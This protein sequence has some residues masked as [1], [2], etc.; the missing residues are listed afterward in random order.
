M[1]SNRVT[2]RLSEWIG[3][4]ASLAVAMLLLTGCAGEE[5]IRTYRVAK[6]E[7]QPA[8]TPP[9]A[10][11]ASPSEDARE[12][13]MLGAIIPKGRSYWVFK[14]ADSPDVVSAHRDEFRE[15]I[16]SLTF[17]KADPQ[18]DLAE[19]WKEN[20]AL[21]GM[22]Y[23]ELLKESEGLRATVTQLPLLSD[24]Q[25]TVKDNINRW[26]GQ[27]A[28]EPSRDWDSL[29]Q[30]LE[31]VEGLNEGDSKAYFVSLVGKGTG[32]MGGGPFQGSSPPSVPRS[33]PTLE[34]TVNPSASRF[35]YKLPDGWVAKEVPPGGMRKA[36]F[37]V[38]GD[39]GSAEVTIVSAG[40]EIRGNVGMWFGQ[41]K[42]EST[43]EAF[44]K[45][46]DSAEPRKINELEAKLYTVEGT[47]D[48]AQAILVAEVPWSERE[49]LFIKM[50]GDAVIVQQS[51]SAF[52]AFLKSLRW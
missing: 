40:G 14:L 42:V 47:G 45:V 21:G 33:E 19:G 27:L 34:Q 7:N 10:G 29:E 51:R 8:F 25:K 11:A 3:G 13:Q 18:W 20:K 2:N 26:R 15:M 30:D 43:D 36:A 50:K 5:G 41:V 38:P 6:S 35:E 49:Q 22:T 32:T 1:D 31:E 28:L 12:I 24:W 39:S 17:D 37:E 52:D 16:A 9:F 48:A 46:L 44:E 23:A 4:L